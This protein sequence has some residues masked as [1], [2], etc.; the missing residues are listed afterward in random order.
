MLFIGRDEFIAAYRRSLL[1][2][3]GKLAN[4]GRY[5]AKTTA[6][7]EAHFRP[8]HWVWAGSNHGESRNV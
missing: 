6:K 3:A 4:T 8:V 7:P 5:V 2:A 1:S